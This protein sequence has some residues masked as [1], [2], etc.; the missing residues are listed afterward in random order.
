M[1]D[2][3]HFSA[4]AQVFITTAR[5]IADL[6]KPA[7][8]TGDDTQYS[9]DALEG[10]L[11]TLAPLVT[12]DPQIICEIIL[13]NCP[14]VLDTLMLTHAKGCYAMPG[15][16]TPE[17]KEIAQHVIS[18]PEVEAAARFVKAGAVISLPA[19]SGP[20][21][22]AIIRD[23]CPRRLSLLVALRNQR[24]AFEDEII[25]VLQKAGPRT[26]KALAQFQDDDTLDLCEIIGNTSL[27][28]MTLKEFAW[29]IASGADFDEYFLLHELEAIAGP[30]AASLV[31]MGASN[32]GRLR[33]SELE[34]SLVA[35]GAGEVWDTF[36]GLS[37]PDTHLL[38]DAQ[39]DPLK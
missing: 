14:K 33:L 20:L 32:H 3:S 36:F 4:E 11:T 16:H 1:Q 21:I 23:D 28:E 13:A 25:E 17:M 30:D 37:S 39:K 5:K 7:R 34:P 12:P 26:A 27:D 18:T 6:R 29:F 9:I 2:I 8:N 38:K 22:D 10:V 35:L 15:I 19:G 31:A 24:P